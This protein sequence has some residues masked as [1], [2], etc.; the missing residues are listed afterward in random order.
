MRAAVLL[1]GSDEL[2]IADVTNDSPIG[3]EVL[4]RSVAAGLCHSDYHY[5]DGTLSRGRPVILGHEGAGVVEAV[6]PDVRD[7][8]VGDHVVTC[9]VMGCGDCVRCVAGEPNRCF[10][11]EVTKR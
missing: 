9:L 3:R 4:V 8:A 5:L 1:D 11:P 6:G 10:H 7:I 2:S